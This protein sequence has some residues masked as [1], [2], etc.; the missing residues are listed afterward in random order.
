MIRDVDLVSYL[1]PYMSLYQETA[2]ALHAED[3]EFTLLWNAADRTLKNV[4]IETADEYGISRFEK[5]LHILPFKEDTLESR[6]SR[7]QSQ[8]F[9]LV[10][11]TIKTLV[12]K[13]TYLCGS[14]NFSITKQFDLYKIIIDTKLEMYGQVQELERIVDEMIPVNMIVITGNTL[15]NMIVDDLF[16][17]SGITNTEMIEIKE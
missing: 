16:V 1:P 10:P 14:Q 8:W 6:R 3:E 2:A 13:L 12:N 9:Q 5:M 7:V 11:Y 15:K 4:F 17:C